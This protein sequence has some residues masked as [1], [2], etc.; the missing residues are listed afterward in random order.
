MRK[1]LFVILV[2]LIVGCS[3]QIQ[4]TESVDKESMDA[5]DDLE[6]ASKAIIADVI[7]NPE[8]V[9][10]C[11]E[12]ADETD[13]GVCYSTYMAIKADKQEDFDDEICEKVQAENR[14]GCVLYLAALRSQS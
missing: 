5:E 12:I 11:E 10:R 9:D 13:K 4:E 2:L 1:I 8:K 14:D 6:D 3:Q 7:I